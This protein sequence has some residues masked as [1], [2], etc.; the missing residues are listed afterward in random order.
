MLAQTAVHLDTLAADAAIVVDALTEGAEAV[1]AALRKL[2]NERPS[3]RALRLESDTDESDDA[4]GSA[5]NRLA[6]REAASDGQWVLDALAPFAFERGCW[7]DLIAL[8]LCG[9][10]LQH[11][12]ALGPIGDLCV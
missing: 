8:S 9:L 12:S 6:L 11:G 10:P 7:R 4:A 3:V 1:C 5:S 2:G